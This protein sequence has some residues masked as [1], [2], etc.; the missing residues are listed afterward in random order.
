[1]VVYDPLLQGLLEELNSFL[2]RRI[3]LIILGGNALCIL[4]IKETT[5]EY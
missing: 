5:H 1:M 4:D 2:T 3:D